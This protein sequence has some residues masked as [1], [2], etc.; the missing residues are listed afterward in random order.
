MTKLRLVFSIVA[1]LAPNSGA[2]IAEQN[3]QIALQPGQPLRLSTGC[4]ARDGLE[5]PPVA[6]AD[7]NGVVFLPSGQQIR[8]YPPF[9]EICRNLPLKRAAIFKCDRM[10]L[11][12]TR[13]PRFCK[14]A[15][16]VGRTC[17]HLVCD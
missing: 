2:A 7:K 17:K 14:R 8:G 10:R 9:A 16:I 3:P 11:A 12:E 5:H 4:V 6:V 15:A 13:N 1:I